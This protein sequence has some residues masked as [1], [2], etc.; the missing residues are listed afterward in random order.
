MGG[1]GNFVQVDHGGGVSTGYGHQV[2]G[3][4]MVSVGQRVEVGQRIGTVGSTGNSTG[5]HLHFETRQGGV[6][7][8]P[9]PLMS[10][11][12]IRL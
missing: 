10:A 8:D 2:N 11:R 5:C 7:A 12:G 1:Y 9:V 4:I 6:A 3:G